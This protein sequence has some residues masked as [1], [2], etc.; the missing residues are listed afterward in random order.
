VLS[1]PSGADFSVLGE[2]KV[3]PIPDSKERVE[4]VWTVKT[5]AGSERGKVVQLNEI[6]AGTLGHYWGDVATVVATEAAGG[7]NEVIR[8][9]SG[10]PA[11]ESTTA[12]NTTSPQPPPK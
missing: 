8:R 12:A 3:V 9:Q 5:G 10:H 1:T 7:L 2:V 11:N 6:P 4:I